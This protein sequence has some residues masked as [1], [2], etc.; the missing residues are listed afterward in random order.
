[1]FC[2]ICLLA[3]AAF[4]GASSSDDKFLLFVGIAILSI[5]SGFR[6]IDVGIDTAFYYDAFVSNFTIRPW[7]FE[8]QGFR[9]F[10]HALMILFGKPEFVFLIISLATNSLVLLRLWD[11]RKTASFSYMSFFYIAV[12]YIGTMNTMRQYFA[13]AIVFFFTRSLER[14]KYVPFVISLLVATSIHTTALAGI[15]YLFIYLWR[16][17]E[18]DK[19]V[20]L[21]IIEVVVI[22]LSVALVI[23]YE[24]ELIDNYFSN[25]ISNVNITFIYRVGSFLLSIFLSWVFSSKNVSDGGFPT[26]SSTSVSLF[27]LI[28]ML[29]SSA[30]MFFK[31]MGRIGYYFTLFE[32]VYWGSAIR[33]KAWDWLYFLMPTVYALYVFANELVFNGSGIFPFHFIFGQL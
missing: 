5:T 9:L 19:R 23:W 17:T 12:F 31:Y 10:V 18:K 26:S 1:M 6:A 13:A 30:G 3:F 27:A 25:G 22:P 7:Q 32:G 2:L 4:T 28:G 11:F 29:A 20:Y 14:K 16:N 8:E 21:L 24:S 15:I 33:A